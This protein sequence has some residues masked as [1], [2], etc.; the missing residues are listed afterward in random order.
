MRVTCRSWVADRST[1]EQLKSAETESEFRAPVLLKVF[2]GQTS[3]RCLPPLSHHSKRRQLDRIEIKPPVPDAVP[4]VLEGH[5]A[6][7][8]FERKVD[9]E[10]ALPCLEPCCVYI[11]WLKLWNASNT[12]P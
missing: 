12:V 11:F 3:G 8:H 7:E 2:H 6:D 10:E 9:T 1:E 5:E 4:L